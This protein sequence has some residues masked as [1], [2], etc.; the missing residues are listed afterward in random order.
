MALS[1]TLVFNVKRNEPRLI[2]AEKPTPNEV[3]QLSDID[4]QEGLRFLLPII[5]FYPPIVGG[6]LDPVKILRDALAKAL[7]Y[8]YP[9][10]GRIFEGPNKK[11]MIN[12]NNEGV[13]FVE[14][15]ANVK[16]D[17]LGDGI[18]P[19]CP[20]MEE[21]MC[22]VPAHSGGIIGCPLLFIQITRFFCGGLSLGVLLN[23]TL[24]D[25]YGATLFLK[26]IIELLKGASA[27][28]IPPVWQ[29]ELLSARS[30][31][32]ITCTHN[33]FEQLVSDNEN[34]EDNFIQ[35]SIFFGP[36]E[37]QALR[38]QLPT[39][40]I[41]SPTRFELITACLWICRTI[42]LEPNPNDITRISIIMN[43]RQKKE[44]GLPTG[45]YGNGI[46]YP[47]AVSKAG[48]LCGSPFMVIKGRP[49][50]ITR[51][52]FLVSD[53]TSLGFDKCDLGWGKPF[54]AG[55]PRAT[56]ILSFYTS[57]KNDGGED[58][59][60]IP[61]CLPALALGKFQNELEKMT[62]GTISKI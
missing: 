3:K 31:P 12:C 4:D 55:V 30:P 29:R 8:Y 61:I 53:T 21:L 62:C 45:Y 22:R 18:L 9:F 5:F 11:L 58:G 23:H 15:D 38:G 35:A 34:P 59:V 44:I 56:S 20:Y 47:A 41:P 50:Y 37:I 7:V 46:V 14:A 60:W 13:V 24:A 26:T 40:Q 16:L 43:A 17:Q 48:D 32:R 49:K 2:V 33:E 39:Y 28:S 10:A 42:A 27:P 1:K 52:N 57:L 19:P 54:Y 51:L 25:G 6:E 36:K